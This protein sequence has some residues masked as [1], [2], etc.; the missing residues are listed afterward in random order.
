MT[1]EVLVTRRGQT[2][3]PIKIRQELGII[4]GTILQ[5]TL[6]NQEIIFRK[7]KSTFDLAGTS[8]LSAKMAK[9]LLDRMRSEE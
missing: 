4:E 9:K 1:K 6:K 5:V 3:I 8:K 7:A 2:T